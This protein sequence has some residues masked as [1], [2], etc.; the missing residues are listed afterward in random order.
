VITHDP[1]RAWD[2]YNLYTN[3]GDQ[4]YLMDMAG[5]R[6]HTWSVPGSRYCSFAR[7]ADDGHVFVLCPHQGLLKL[8]ARAN[9]V[10]K[11]RGRVHHDIA[12][13]PGGFVLPTA[14]KPREYRGRPVTFDGLVE[15]SARGERRP[16]WSVYERLDAIRALHGPTR[17]DEPPAA[18]APKPKPRRTDGKDRPPRYDYHHLNAVEVLA[19]T[20]LGRRD[21]RFRPGNLL[22]SLRNANV[23]AIL[24]GTTLDVVWHWGQEVLDFPHM[25]TM[26]DGGN[27]LV[28][29]NGAHRDFSRVLEVEPLTGKIAWSYVA[30]PPQT[31]YSRYA[32]SSQRLPNGNTLICESGRGRAFEVTPSG[33]IVWEFL[34]PDVRG[35]R[36]RTIYRMMRYARSRVDAMLASFAG[37][38]RR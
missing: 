28:F 17:L 7:L 2:G 5:R 15:V 11:A 29:D 36:R 27:I 35:N 34:N 12:F 8:D 31:F 38:A 13:K 3:D 10:W 22:V 14:D 32:G 23:L 19:D 37:Q 6:V 16:L 26:V 9:V 25:P 24:D 4:V 20:P 1:A 30:D 33:E 21:A 18:D